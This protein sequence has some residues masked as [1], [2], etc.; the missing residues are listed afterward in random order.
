MW[1]TLQTQRH[2]E[3]PCNQ[4][5]LIITALAEALPAERDRNDEINRP[6]QA[7]GEAR[8]WKGKRLAESEVATILEAVERVADGAIKRRPRA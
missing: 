1:V 3:R 4:R 5:D 8:K 6:S 7:R 2:G